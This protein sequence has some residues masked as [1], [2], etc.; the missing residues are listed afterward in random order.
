LTS[1]VRFGLWDKILAAD[2]FSMPRDWPYQR[3]L[4]RYARA[5]ALVHKK[6]QTGAAR[7]LAALQA[8]LP[9][10]GGRYAVYA[11]V[12]NLTAAAVVALGAGMPGTAVPL[13]EAAA[14]E[15]VGRRRWLLRGEAGSVLLD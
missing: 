6:N 1:F 12:A 4:A 2:A 8:L 10:L 15:Q 3:V 13:L 14:I 5:I 7:E 11:R 9:T